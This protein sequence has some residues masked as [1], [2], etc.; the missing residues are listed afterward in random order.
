VPEELVAAKVLDIDI[1]QLA[2][3]AIDGVPA[4]PLDFVVLPLVVGVA[5]VD[6]A[7]Q[8]RVLAEFAPRRAHSLRARQDLDG[9]QSHQDRHRHVPGQLQ[10]VPELVCWVRRR[11]H[12]KIFSKWLGFSG[13]IKSRGL[14]LEM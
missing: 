10:P 12:G 4:H 3:A 13:K 6:G 8:R 11:V 14:C 2:A 1:D 5:H 7:P 9:A